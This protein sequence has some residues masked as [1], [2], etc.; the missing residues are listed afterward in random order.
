[1]KELS[2]RKYRDRVGNQRIL[3]EIMVCTA[4]FFLR[5]E[6]YAQLDLSDIRDSQQVCEPVY[7][8]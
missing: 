7:R 8:K 1:M 5:F 2:R 6:V 3:A 4:T